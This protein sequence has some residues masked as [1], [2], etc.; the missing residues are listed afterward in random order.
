MKQWIWT[1]NRI[2]STESIGLL[3]STQNKTMK[4]N[5][6]NNKNRKCL[7]MANLEILV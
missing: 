5:H 2:V 1:I 6:K 4:L 7:K 3:M